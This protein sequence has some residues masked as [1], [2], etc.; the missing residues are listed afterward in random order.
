[1]ERPAVSPLPRLEG[2][3]HGSKGLVVAQGTGWELG[4]RCRKQ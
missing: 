4:A 1:M 2:V 3:A